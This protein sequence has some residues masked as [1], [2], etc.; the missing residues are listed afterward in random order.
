M[1]PG[2]DMLPSQL[3]WVVLLTLSAFCVPF[4]IWLRMAEDTRQ[5]HEAQMTAKAKAE[6]ENGIL[7]I[8][9]PKTQPRTPE[10]IRIQVNRR[11]S[12]P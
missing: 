10:K 3:V 8:R 6:A 1:V 9:I 12:R 5:R 11:G 7:T 4:W 2:D